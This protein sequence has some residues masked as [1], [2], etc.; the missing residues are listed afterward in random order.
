MERATGTSLLQGSAPETIKLHSWH[1]TLKMEQPSF[2]QRG[3]QHPSGRQGAPA[4]QQ[5]CM[6]RQQNPTFPEHPAQSASLYMPTFA[7]QSAQHNTMFSS[8]TASSRAILVK[9]LFLFN[10]FFMIECS[11]LFSFSSVVV[12]RIIFW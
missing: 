10:T 5:N 6:F 3:P 12:R 8:S 9:Y 7:Q 1:W 11:S 2:S 4:L